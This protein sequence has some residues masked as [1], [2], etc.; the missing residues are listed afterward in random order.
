MLH[1][2]IKNKNFLTAVEKLNTNTGKWKLLGRGAY[3]YAYDMGDGRVCKITTNAQETKAAAKLLRSKK[4]YTYLYKILNVLQID[5]NDRF[6]LGLIVTPKYKKLTDN[7]KVELYELF[8]FLDLTPNF[9]IRSIDQIK[10]KILRAVNDY[11]YVPYPYDNTGVVN[12][13]VEKRLKIFKKY[14]I[15]HIL[16]NLKAANLGPEDMHY[17]NILKD[18]NKFILIDIAC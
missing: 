10:K 5:K 7:Q 11:C 2:L 13:M 1:R 9:R 16:R 3:G 18:E 12:N 8:C 6:W 17:D 15:L 14:N 4:K